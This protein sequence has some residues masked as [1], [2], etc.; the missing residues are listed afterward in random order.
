MYKHSKIFSM[1]LLG[2]ALLLGSVVSMSSPVL[3]LAEDDLSH[4][5]F[6]DAAGVEVLDEFCV[7]GFYE[8]ELREDEFREEDFYDE[9][10][11]YPEE[12]HE[13]E[14]REDEYREES[15]H[16]F[17]DELR[18]LEEEWEKADEERFALEEE[19]HELRLE[20]SMDWILEDVEGIREDI[21]AMESPLSLMKE[22]IDASLDSGIA[23]QSP[24]DDERVLHDIS[25]MLNTMGKA[26]DLLDDI[27][28]TASDLDD[29]VEVDELFA[30]LES[31]EEFVRPRFMSAIDYLSAN[32]DRMDLNSDDEAELRSLTE[33]DF[34][35]EDEFD[36]E[37]AR[38][39]HDVY[40]RDAVEKMEHLMGDRF[41]DVVDDMIQGISAPV[42]EEFTDYLG[43]HHIE[44]YA[45]RFVENIDYFDKYEGD[46]ANDLLENN[47]L[48]YAQWDELEVGSYGELGDIKDQFATE[49][50][51]DDEQAQDIANY[52]YEMRLSLEAD[53]SQAQIDALIAEGESLFE[54][55]RD[56]QYE[57]R[58][59]MTDVPTVTDEDYDETWWAS[60][61]NDG[62]ASGHW[63][64]Y[65]S[66]DR[67]GEFGANDQTLRA[68]AMKMIL[69][70]H[71][72]EESSS[73]G[74]N[75]WDGWYNRGGS[76]GMSLA[77]LD[78]SELITRGEFFQAIY[79][80][81]DY[82]ELS[83]CDGIFPDVS[84]SHSNCAAAAAL[85]A[86]GVV[87]GDGATG[88][89]RLNERINRAEA[90]ALIIRAEEIYEDVIFEEELLGYEAES[91]GFLV[92]SRML[93][94]IF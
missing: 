86:E 21:E 68:E 5:Y 10:D 46:F 78:A 41:D 75:W 14:Y 53:P 66:E 31:L 43:N 91:K 12:F 34:E 82:E 54:N 2:G 73:S 81:G 32:L 24:H 56:D 13:D 94:G 76:I 39:A 1:S 37:K 59:R 52:F 64:G 92:L 4:C 40:D 33:F 22:T 61:A 83:S 48:V 90:A 77:S 35:G 9:E 25:G 70:A 60:Y 28:D 65:Q 27:E 72:Y 71:G 20:E 85:W 62:F 80:A 3:Q 47:N 79:D 6:I 88:E 30:Q 29:V 51:P 93:E 63:S 87:T 69:A 67:F 17:E 50:I 18:E 19:Y 84:S 45:G 57:H 58:I 11:F 15:F 23:I 16:N 55:L 74:G 8:D 89:A 36:D 49:M 38:R 26:L 44:D 42:M 7:D